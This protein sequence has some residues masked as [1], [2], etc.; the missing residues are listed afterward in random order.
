MTRM[1]EALTTRFRHIHGLLYY[2]VQRRKSLADRNLQVVLRGL[3]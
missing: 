2:D 1:F 3:S